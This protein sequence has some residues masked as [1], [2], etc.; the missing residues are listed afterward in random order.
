MIGRA[1]VQTAHHRATL[2][3]TA[4]VFTLAYIVAPVTSANAKPDIT[5]LDGAT[6]INVSARP[7][8][9]WERGKDSD[10]FGRLIF[11]GGLTL[12]SPSAYFGGFSGLAVAP[13]GGSLVAVSDAGFWLRAHISYGKD[14]APVGLSKAEVGPMRALSG[15]RLDGVRETDAEGIV[16]TSG[17]PYAGE[18]LITF[19]RLHRVGVF[20]MTKD[21]V[22]KPKRYLKLPKYIK[23][24]HDNRGIEAVTLLR[25]GRHNGAALIF[26]EGRRDARGHM[27]GWLLKGGGSQEI[28]L[29]RSDDFDVTDVAGLPDGGLLVLE[30]YFSWVRGVR[31]RLRHVPAKEVRAG[32]VMRGEV[33]V[34]A[35]G[36]QRIDNME[37]LAV[38]RD[39]TGATI[40]TLISD[41]NFKFFQSTILLQ[42][43]LRE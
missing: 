22:A 24:L 1:K 15:R 16:L 39:K 42:F 3:I 27:R 40:V 28:F 29:T 6:S 14:G 5:K 18:A 31:M 19:E 35:T 32:K 30:R 34:A 8:N 10:T 33:L 17:S 21:G 26:A 41:D 12:S 38:H 2:W 13:D 9:R 37:G 36:R 20:P 23:G 4:A 7:F 43:E 25:G 11:R